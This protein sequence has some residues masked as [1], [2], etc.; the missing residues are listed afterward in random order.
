[1]IVSP[2]DPAAYHVFLL[3][4]VYEAQLS[5]GIWFDYQRRRYSKRLGIG[6]EGSQSSTVRAV[7]SAWK[8]LG[9]AYNL[10]GLKRVISQR[11][12]L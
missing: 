8:Q 1:M 3:A 2:Y 12:S 5:A 9:P 4:I 6:G 7:P 11:W 10:K